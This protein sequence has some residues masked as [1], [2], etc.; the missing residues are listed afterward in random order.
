MVLQSTTLQVSHMQLA[1]QGLFLLLLCPDGWLDEWTNEKIA[2]VCCWVGWDQSV[3]LYVL[4]HFKTFVCR[5]TFIF[6]FSNK[7]FFSVLSLLLSLSISS[8]E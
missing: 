7:F 3:C 1:T 5:H 8:E 6:L 2:L 4:K